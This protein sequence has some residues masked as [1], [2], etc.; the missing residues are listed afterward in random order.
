MNKPLKEAILNGFYDQS[1]LGH[2]L[3]G[4]KLLVNDQNDNNI[5]LT[6]K[7]ELLSCDNFIWAVA[8]ITQDMLIPLK[9]VLADLAKEKISGTLITGDYLGFNDPK[10]F[11]ELKKIPNLTVKIANEDGFHAKGYLFEHSDYQTVVIG[12][13]NFTRNA[14]LNNYEWSLKVSSSENATLTKQIAKQIKQ[15]QKNSFNLT[16]DWL[17]DYRKNWSAPTR[18]KRNNRISQEIIPNQMQKAALKNLNAL[19]KEKKQKAL[20]VSATGTGKTY[21]GAFAVK[22]FKP[23]RFLYVVHRQQIAKKSLKSFKKVIGGNSEDFGLLSGTHH[24]MQCKYLFATVQ[25]LS[26]EKI[27]H[28]FASHDFDYILIDEAHRSTS[29]SYQR[30]LKYFE[31][32][33][34]LGMTATPERMDEQDVYGI[35]DYNLA[36]EI[37]L[38]DALEVKMLTPFHYIGVQD[39]EQNGQ[40]I[41]ETTDLKYL[42]AD[43]RVKYILRQIE[44]YGYCGNQPKGLVFCS[45]QKEAKLLADKFTEA[46]HKAISLTNEDAQNYRQQAVNQLKSGKIEYIVTVDLFNEGIDIPQLNQIIMLRNTQSSIVFIQQLGRGLRKYPGKDFVTVLDFIGNYK[47]NYLIPAALNDDQSHDASAARR[48]IR[49]PE[50]VGLSTINFSRVAAEK[51][52]ASLDKTKLDSLH[53]LR[54]SYLSLKERIGRTPYLLDF[55]KYHSVS[56]VII[57]QNKLFKHYGDFLNKMG[58]QIILSS[59]ESRILF[60]MT[61]E[62]L[63]GKRPHELLLLKSLLK[64]Q[65]IS[66]SE[67]LVLLKEN[68]AYVNPAVLNSIDNILDLNFF[69]IKTGKTTKKQQYGGQSLIEHDLLNYRCSA[70]LKQALENPEFKKL[71]ID[72]ISTGLILTKKYRA[73]KQF[74]LYQ[75]YDRK[76]VC[77]LLNWPKDVS[78]PMYGYRVGQ[79][80]TPIFITYQKDSSEKRNAIYDN[81]LQNGYRLRWYTRSPRHLTSDEVQRLLHNKEMTIHLFVKR[82]DI[83]GKNFF[84]LGPATIQKDSVREEKIGPKQKSVVGMDLI[85]KE[86]LSQQMYGLLFA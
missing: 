23:K 65:Q 7:Q 40:T 49:M 31:P 73:T 50:L 4:P 86:P 38:R 70:A 52:L 60:F 56:P 35:F 46:G 32:Q 69:D 80:E 67:F 14:L 78:A 21:L 17:A 22:S 62:L 3:L 12:S 47:N 34:L 11:E 42:T 20:V 44:Y 82:N 59:A 77:R 29:P 51:I 76:D 13:A 71:F 10:V 27:L 9:A 61:K 1:F 81:T 16:E 6:L 55:V 84:Y 19:V 48:E 33:F 57:A 53:E 2:E 83:S 58:E 63:N 36:Y 5:W 18:T 8:F 54:D 66:E 74:T 75:Q 15:L 72:I 30:I 26:Q 85:L 28:Q 39:Y 25:T 45:R 37:R 43:A 68:D 41:D 79:K 64:E 24:D